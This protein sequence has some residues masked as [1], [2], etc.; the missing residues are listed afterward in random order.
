MLARPG[1]VLFLDGG[2][3]GRRRGAPELDEGGLAERL[4]LLV[5]VVDRDPGDRDNDQRDH[6]TDR[7]NRHRPASL[8]RLRLLA[9]LLDDFAAL[10]VLARLAHVREGPSRSECDTE[11]YARTQLAPWT[12]RHSSGGRETSAP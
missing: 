8:G 5:L 3:P 9:Q 6:D 7:E 1:A 10:P 11:V 2:A 4:G 12:A